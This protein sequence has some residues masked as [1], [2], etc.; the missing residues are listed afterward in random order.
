LE[1][2]AKRSARAPVVVRVGTV[3]FAH[4]IPLNQVTVLEPPLSCKM[5]TKNIC[6]ATIFETVRVIFPA[7]IV[8]KN[9]LSV[10][11]SKSCVAEA[12]G[13]RLLVPCTEALNIGFV[14]VLT[15][16]I[17]CVV[18]VSTTVLSNLEAA[19]AALPEISALTNAKALR[20]LSN[21]PLS[22]LAVKF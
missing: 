13:L 6:P 17:V 10:E 19:I 9:T 14:I 5:R 4:V 20:A 2:K 11:P 16:V 12:E 3:A 18:S 22:A 8:I 21:S 15:P 7:G 1:K